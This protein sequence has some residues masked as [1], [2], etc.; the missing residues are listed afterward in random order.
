M[1]PFSQT[2]SSQ[3]S[4][5]IVVEQN[6]A[7]QLNDK[8]IVQETI[9]ELAPAPVLTDQISHPHAQ[10]DIKDFVPPNSSMPATIADNH[11]GITFFVTLNC[12][13]GY[14]ILFPRAMSPMLILPVT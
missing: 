5:N 2:I 13:N 10:A 3:T 1:L 4:F 9:H 14:I 7:R 6:V 8:G 12:F 11:A